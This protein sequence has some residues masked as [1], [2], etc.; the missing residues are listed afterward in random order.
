SIAELLEHFADDDDVKVVA[1]VFEG[2]QDGPAF[3]R[4]V[5]RLRDAGKPVVAL[6]LGRTTAGSAA[7]ASHTGSLAGE[8]A[9]IS[10]VLRQHGVI[11][12]DDLDD[13]GATV[14]AALGG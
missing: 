6:K 10:A 11:E 5:G 14:A 8:Y 3:L 1:T 12:V 7:A 9:T 4:A 13:F 2:I